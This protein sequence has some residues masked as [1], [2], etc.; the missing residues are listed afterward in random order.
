MKYNEFAKAIIKLKKEDLELRSQLIQKGS[1][2]DNYNQEMANLHISNAKKLNEIMNTIGGYPTIDK[3]GKEASDSAWLV[4]QHAI[5]QPHFMKKCLLLLKIAVDEKKANP[6]NLAYLSDRIATFENNLQ[7]YGTQFDW[8]E[9]GQ[10][11][12][13]PYDDLKKVNQRRKSLGLNSLEEQTQIMRQQILTE[14]QSPPSDLPKR[15]KEF[16]EWRKSVGWIN[17]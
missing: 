16:N 6:I 13:L 7:S 3:V 17:F 5:M 9:L 1:L 8:D 2:G 4:I 10:M 14:N 12:P 11:S 15:K